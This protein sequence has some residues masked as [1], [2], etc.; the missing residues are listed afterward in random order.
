[1]HRFFFSLLLS[2]VVLTRPLFAQ[3]VS[4]AAAKF[5]NDNLASYSLIDA[6][7]AEYRKNKPDVPQPL[8]IE[9]SCHDCEDAGKASNT[10]QAIDAWV[11]S[12]LQPEE[13]MIKN[14]LQ[15]QQ[16][17]AAVD[18]SLK[19]EA[20]VPACFKKF[21][22]QDFQE[23][24][25]F[26]RDRIFLDKILPMARKWKGNASTFLA[27]TQAI[28]QTL[29]Y[30]VDNS[31]F[32]KQEEAKGLAL[33]W[34]KTYCDMIENAVIKS[35]QYRFF[36]ALAFD[37]AGVVAQNPEA[38][39]YVQKTIERLNDFMHFTLKID[40]EASGHGDN[41]GKYHA[42]ASGEGKVRA[43]IEDGCVLWETENGEELPFNVKEV[44]F[45]SDQ[46]QAS[47]AGPQQF[48]VP[49]SIKTNLCNGDAK[50]KIGFARFGAD[51]EAYVADG[52]TFQSR[53]LYSLAMATL[54]S[55]N[56][57]RMK[58]EATKMQQKAEKFSGKEA[59]VDAAA[60]RL[61]DHQNDPNYLKTP[62][63]KADMNTMRQMAKDL[64]YS[65]VKA[66]DQKRM[67]NL[68]NLRAMN[69]AQ[70]RINAKYTQPGYVG[71]PEYQKDQAE[72][73]KLRGG[74]NMND[75]ASASGFDMNVLV[76]EAPFQ[77]GTTT[78]ADKT[79]KDKIKEI[80]GTS[81]G[82]EFGQF[83]IRLEQIGSN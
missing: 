79:Q 43:R 45:K 4:Q 26:L 49:V 25:S 30:A 40:F 39:A 41:G 82:W 17:W 48:T 77:N 55:A 57:E 20:N 76:I 7:I 10:Q 13:K 9:M 3:P 22:E 19:A 33:T 59:T 44:L 58:S 31:R 51:N 6:T 36:A 38:T 18:R 27:G 64:C 54:G 73:A 60:R 75:L 83:H 35:H 72:L 29:H 28:S 23:K 56:L 2:A 80:A 5:C 68:E 50:I 53:L 14:L 67:K 32:D 70:Q 81:N 37:A 47:Y 63:G 34:T 11:K 8:A 74:V 71:S 78:L 1:M 21:S 65:N 66:P 15:M 61:R 69:A 62:Q 46:G 16:D 42:L 52:Q 12:A 24:L